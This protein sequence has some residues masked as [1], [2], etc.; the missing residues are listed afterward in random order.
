MTLVV[1]GRVMRAALLVAFGIVVGCSG[2]SGSS[3]GTGTTAGSI[4]GMC[5][6]Y[7]DWKVRCAKQDQDCSA[8]CNSDLS[9]SDGK[10]SSAYAS[11]WQS[12]FQGLACSESEDSCIANFGAADPSHPNIAE[13][14]ACEEKRKECSQA[15][16]SPDGGTGTAPTTSWSDDYCLSITALTPA[17][18]A[19]ANACLS[20]PCAGIRDCLIRAGAFNY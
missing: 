3:S 20:E 2:G 14:T 18:R 15:T 19:D 7:C 17:A 8:E 16:S 13:G 10:L 12:C 11:M 9:R 4:S 6:A 5:T 1:R